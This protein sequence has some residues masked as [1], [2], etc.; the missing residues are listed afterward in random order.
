MLS[1][2]SLLLTILTV[3]GIYSKHLLLSFFFFFFKKKSLEIPT[4]LT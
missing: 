3:M 2:E 4:A 1:Q